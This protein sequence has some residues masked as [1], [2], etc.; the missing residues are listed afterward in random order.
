[1]P[2]FSPDEPEQTMT[3]T[4]RVALITG[5][6]SGIGRATARLFLDAGFSV[7]LAGRRELP[8]VE[9]AA[10]HPDALVV[11]TDVTQPADVD[12]LFSTIQRR[13]GRID[14]LF[15]NAGALGPSASVDEISLDD[16]ERCLAVNVTGPMLCSAAAIRLMKS[17]LPGG[18]RIINNGS[19]SAQRPRPGTVAYTVTKHALTGLTKAIALDGRDFGITCG[20]IDIGNVRTQVTADLGVDTGARQPNGTLLVEPMFDVEDAARV[21]LMM[22]EL[23]KNATIGSVTI[24]AS[25]MPFDGRG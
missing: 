3:G 1:M 5:A 12:R 19:I 25:G 6:G 21:V 11:P 2:A 4:A 10:G 14:V 22:A 16:W 24:T 7:C 20:Q 18:G 15:N 8:L 13:L 23:P 17:Q 9:S